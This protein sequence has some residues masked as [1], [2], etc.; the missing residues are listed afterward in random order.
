MCGLGATLGR[1]DHDDF[2]QAFGEAIEAGQASL[3]IG[4]GLSEDAGYPSWAELLDPVAQ[5]FDVPAM[6]DLPQRAQYIENQEGGRDALRSHVARA[7]GGVMPRPQKSHSLLA[8]LGISDIWTTN[9]DTLLETEDSELEVIEQDDDLAGRATGMR[10]LNKMHG[11]IPAGADEPVG[12]HGKLVLSRDDYDRYEMTHPRLWRLLQAQFLTSSFCFLGF[13]M[14]DPNF[15]AVFRITRLAT[16]DRLMQHYAVMKRPED[17]DG[18]FDLRACDLK[19]VGI[20]L[21]EIEDFGDVTLLLDRLV[22]RTRP[23][24]LFVSGS[25]R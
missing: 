13:S 21:V 4:A 23:A 24:Q 2:V 22:A 7:V 12:G 17:D 11:S 9:Y 5:D 25:F 15:D 18:L 16:P 8:R 10:H 3:L 14:T 6:S 1:V 19:R 20:K